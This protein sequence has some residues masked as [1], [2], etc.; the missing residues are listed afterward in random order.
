M[1]TTESAPRNG[2][3]TSATNPAENAP[4]NSVRNFASRP[5]TGDEYIESLRDD[6]EIWLHGERVKDVTTH[7]AFRNPVRMTARLY[8]SMHTGEHVDAVTT[9]T[10]TGNGGVTMPF[11]KAPTSAEDMLKERDAIATWARMTYGWMGRSPDYKA[12]FLGTL[13]ANKEL[14]SPFQANAERWYKESQEKVLYWNHAIINPPVDRQ[15]PPDEVGD[16]FMKVE[17]ETDAGLIVSGAKVVATAFADLGFDVD[18]GPL[19]QTPEE[20]ARQAIEN[21]V[22]A[23]GVSTLAAVSR[24]LRLPAQASAPTIS[25][26]RLPRYSCGVMFFVASEWIIMEIRSGRGSLLARSFQ[27]LVK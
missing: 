27:R 26:T 12:S 25:S 14:Y 13:H 7:P 22:H 10:D 5:M 23:V 16:V 18:M 9:P 11:F 1:T 3:D 2:I 19:F 8:D 21:D 15:L 17:K 24:T 4:A 6:R 20:C